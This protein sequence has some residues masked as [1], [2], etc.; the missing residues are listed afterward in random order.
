MSVQL[1]GKVMRNKYV[2]LLVLTLATLASSLVLRNN[3]VAEGS[4]TERYG[5][6]AKRCSHNTIGMATYACSWQGYAFAKMKYVD[7]SGYDGDTPLFSSDTNTTISMPDCSTSGADGFFIFGS[8]KY[9]SE[10]RTESYPNSNTDG[11]S[12]TYRGLF[13]GG[14]NDPYGD[15]WVAGSHYGNRMALYMLGSNK[16]S[17]NASL[18]EMYEPPSPYYGNAICASYNFWNQCTSWSYKPIRDFYGNARTTG[19]KH[20]GGVADSPLVIN[21]NGTPIAYLSDILIPSGDGTGGD[22][23]AMLKD[24]GLKKG[25]DITFWDGGGSYGYNANNSRTLSRDWDGDGINETFYPG[26]YPNGKNLPGYDR[27]RYPLSNDIYLHADNPYYIADDS[28]SANDA[29]SAS[30]FNEMIDS[31]KLAYAG[32]TDTR[33]RI[34]R[35][36]ICSWSTAE[37]DP[38]VTLVEGGRVAA[39]RVSGESDL[40]FTREIG[41]NDPA[42]TINFGHIVTRSDNGNEE[43]TING[44]AVITNGP[45]SYGVIQTRDFSGRAGHGGSVEISPLSGVIANP[46]AGSEVT[47]CAVTKTGAKT[48]GR[49]CVTVKRKKATVSELVPAS[50]IRKS[51]GSKLDGCSTY[52]Q[53]IGVGVLD[54]SKDCPLILPSD[55]KV[56]L[57]TKYSV[58]K[59]NPYDQTNEKYNASDLALGADTSIKFKIKHSFR[60]FVSDDSYRYDTYGNLYGKYGGNLRTRNLN[61]GYAKP[62]S[63]YSQYAIGALGLDVEWTN[64]SVTTNK[65]TE[66]LVTKDIKYGDLIRIKH[67]P[68]TAKYVF[69]LG[70]NKYEDGVKTT[71][72][73]FDVYLYKQQANCN[74][75]N[76]YI[77]DPNTVVS[78]GIDSA[79]NYGGIRYKNYTT[80]RVAIADGNGVSQQTAW[81]RPMDSINFGNY[82]CSGSN[83]AVENSAKLSGWANK[84]ANYKLTTTTRNGGS[85]RVW[86]RKIT[87]KNPAS[88]GTDPSSILNEDGVY[89]TSVTTPKITSGS[90]LTCYGRG[91]NST[92]IV[93]SGYANTSNRCNS[94]SNMDL[95]GS[96]TE[97]MTWKDYPIEN[98]ALTNVSGID[99]SASVEVKVPYNYYIEP[100]VES[101]GSDDMIYPD[102]SAKKYNIS[103]NVKAR[104]NDVV[105][106]DEYATTTKHTKIQVITYKLDSSVANYTIDNKY[107]SLPSA[108]YVKSGNILN[109]IR[110]N[111]NVNNNYTFVSQYELKGENS[112]E[113]SRVFNKPSS[114][115]TSTSAPDSVPDY[116]FSIVRNDGTGTSQ[117]NSGYNNIAYDEGVEFNIGDK[118]CVVVAAYPADSHNSIGANANDPNRFTLSGDYYQDAALNGDDGQSVQDGYWAISKPS[119]GSTGKRPNMSVESSWLYTTQSVK[120]IMTRRSAASRY[121][122]SWAEYGILSTGNSKVSMFASSASIAYQPGVYPSN[123]NDRITSAD[124]GGTESSTSIGTS[125]CSNTELLTISSDCNPDLYTNA[126]NLKAKL[127][128]KINRSS[129]SLTSYLNSRFELGTIS[130]LSGNYTYTGW[131]SGL[132]IS[133]ASS[134]VTYNAEA[135]S[136]VLKSATGTITLDTGSGS[137]L[138]FNT[139]DVKTSIVYAKNVVINSNI[140]V[141]NNPMSSAGQAKAVIIVATGDI[142]IAS[143][144]TRID[145]WLVSGGEINTCYKDNG[146]TITNVKDLA[147]DVC[148][149]TL[150]IDAPVYAKNI[151]LFR[152]AGGSGAVSGSGGMSSDEQMKRAEVFNFNTVNY[153]WAQT[154]IQSTETITTTDIKELPVR[155]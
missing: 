114:S 128:S 38:K 14:I 65:I 3:A 74:W 149:Q 45:S 56:V 43:K 28:V 102:G 50:T 70:S 2:I 60:T 42:Y 51:D 112:G 48:T 67:N 63:N 94:I 84:K 61:W 133:N 77:T 44:T 30:L 76:Y 26:F 139:G 148:N 75:Y 119:C 140:I 24:L 91:S 36:G 104:K 27:E 115:S 143:N 78:Y 124:G 29:G 126:T 19:S 22:Q 134:N 52:P 123:P 21:Y 81:A 154:E 5:N 146:R 89:D 58:A 15:E 59:P 68:S 108:T 103:I 151:K 127:E 90:S 20:Y 83:Y 150:V 87:A 135:N 117:N 11:Y 17:D 113:T 23:N 138:N 55:G 97:T 144:V 106:N 109:T 101:S 41:V 49:I 57:T 40:S 71:E 141:S 118:I 92:Y 12:I 116:A 99:K 88:S 110:D 153:F 79:H 10:R 69:S 54:G 47:Y 152:T 120:G 46:A 62:G 39:T 8:L 72:S 155:Y 80:N 137:D 82:V 16:V 130:G 107:S 53:N 9:S 34:P 73:G 142:K 66:T 18:I 31:Y 85:S 96:F 147:L 111:Y 95:G 136:A 32:V 105:D 37:Q 86:T 131:D 121:Y 33:E 4:Y 35:A 64:Q 132:A 129:T 145:A 7:G 13:V 25:N 122:G 93:T 98:Y 1:K 6:V 125:M 100:T